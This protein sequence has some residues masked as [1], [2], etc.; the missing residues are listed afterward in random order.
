MRLR[1]EA[2]ADQDGDPVAVVGAALDA[3]V[4]LLDTA[5]LYRNESL[6]GRAIHDRRDEVTLCTKF[7]VVRGDGDD[8]SVRADAPVVAHDACE[9]SLRRLGVDVIDLCH[10]PH[11]SDTTPIEETVMALGE[12]VTAGKV[13]ALGLSNV[14]AEDVRRAV[15]SGRRERAGCRRPPLGSK[16]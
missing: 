16:V 14:T 2:G 1:D 7:G 12:L 3:G 13:R 15:T 11:R 6:V 9:A 5:D 8:W 10:L 4:G